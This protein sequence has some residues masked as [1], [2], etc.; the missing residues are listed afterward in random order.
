[1]DDVKFDTVDG[2][3]YAYTVENGEA[4]I[5][6]V[7]TNFSNPPKSVFT[8]ATDLGGY[9]VTAIGNSN[10]GVS[11]FLYLQYPDDIVPENPV[12]YT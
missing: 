4:I 9:P 5:F 10:F 7:R 2:A 1:M 12:N 3:D 11:A 6:N 8:F